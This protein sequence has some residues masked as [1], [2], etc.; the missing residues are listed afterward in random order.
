MSAELTPSEREADRNAAEARAA[1]ELREAIAQVI[2]DTD[3]TH[4]STGTADALIAGPLA[5]LLA[6]NHTDVVR[7]QPDP[8]SRSDG[9]S[10]ALAGI[11]DRD[12]A[13]L[14]AF[15]QRLERIEQKFDAISQSSAS[16]EEVA[17]RI[18]NAADGG[19]TTDSEVE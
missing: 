8:E 4:F 18:L 9:D 7:P 17:V 1:M 12:E 6:S 16:M 13:I 11:S 2:R 15:S 10:V 5:G 19:A 3:G 14:V